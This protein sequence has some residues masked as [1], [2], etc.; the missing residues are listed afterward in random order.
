MNHNLSFDCIYRYGGNCINSMLY[1]LIAHSVF[2]ILY[3]LK[4]LRENTKCKILSST[5]YFMKRRMEMYT[6]QTPD[7]NSSPPLV[8]LREIIRHQEDFV[9]ALIILD[10]NIC[11]IYIL[12]PLFCA[13]LYVIFVFC[14]LFVCFYIN[15]QCL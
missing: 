9:M 11:N 4:Y 12:S 7:P 14:F 13:C 10:T 6:F 15:Y 3:L 8:L 5:P 1:I 2:S